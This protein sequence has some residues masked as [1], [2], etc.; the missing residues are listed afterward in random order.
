MSGKAARKSRAQVPKAPPPVGQGGGGLPRTWLYAGIGGIAAVV[1][2]VLVLVTTLGGGGDDSASPAGVDGAQ[3]AKL[4][5]GIPQDGLWLGDPD[6]PVIMYEF[7]DLQCPFCQKASTAVLPELIS[8]YVRPGK[9]RIQLRGLSFIGP[10]SE[11]ALRAVVAAG[12]QDKAWHVEHLLYEHQGDENDGW[13]TDQLLRDVGAAVA[14]LEVER[15]LDD[16]DSDA[17]DEAIGTSAGEAQAGGVR[18]TPTFM[19]AKAGGKLKV[20]DYQTLEPDPFRAALDELLG[21]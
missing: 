4:L 19:A 5:D 10:D 9:V 15:M 13:V 8:D 21:S 17:V 1:A 20:I 18:S 11:K 12:L 3:T 6:A 7:V 14:G 16:M 2:I